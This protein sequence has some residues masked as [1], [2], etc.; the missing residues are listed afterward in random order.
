MENETYNVIENEVEDDD[1]SWDAADWCWLVRYEN[2][3]IAICASEAEAEHIKELLNTKPLP[4][5]R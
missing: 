2:E 1:D 4:G 3:I 5:H